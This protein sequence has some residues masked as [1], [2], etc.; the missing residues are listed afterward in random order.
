MQKSKTT[1]FAK[2][3]R[4]FTLIITISLMVL[5]T[6]I[7]IGLL[8]LSTVT[9]R[10]STQADAMSVARSN[11]RVALILAINELQK[12]AGPDQRITARSDILGE[13]LMRPRLTGVWKSRN[14]ITT[15]PTTADYSAASKKGLFLNWLTSNANPR[16]TINQDFANA[17]ASNPI[18]LWDKGT[19]GSDAP[20]ADFIEAG[21]MQVTSGGGRKSA[22]AWAVSDEGIKARINTPYDKTAATDGAKTAQL[23]SG[24]RDRK[25]VV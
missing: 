21:K 11:A 2:P 3:G 8:S 15:Q 22:F 12:S 6:L 1:L 23:G 18:R 14:P 19:L 25:S 13:N 10:T 20:V 16:D 4:G 9:L 17:L 5:L 7:G 24:E